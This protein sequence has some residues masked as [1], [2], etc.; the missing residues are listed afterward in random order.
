MT[1]SAAPSM[2]ST[3][4]IEEVEIVR[5]SADFAPRARPVPGAPLWRSGLSWLTPAPLPAKL[6]VTI[7]VAVSVDRG[8]AAEMGVQHLGAF[9]EEALLHEVD[10]ALHGFTLIDRIGNHCLGARR[11][12][13]RLARLTARHAI[14]RIRIVL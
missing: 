13:D 8:C 4:P 3:L 14:G 7:D 1:S 2:G 5:G 9:R 6:A 10:H 11:E 12:S